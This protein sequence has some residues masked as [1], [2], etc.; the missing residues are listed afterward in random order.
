M[1]DAGCAVNELVADDYGFDVHV[2]LPE[3]YP[4]DAPKW[5]MSSQ[6]ALLQIKGGKSFDKGVRLTHAMWRFYL[7]SPTPTYLAVIPSSAAPW[8]ELVDRLAGALDVPAA[9]LPEGDDERASRLQP[10]PGTEMW[11]AQLF[12]ED[13]RLYAAADGRRARRDLLAWAGGSRGTGDVDVEFL[14]TLAELAFSR[15]GSYE[16]LAARVEEYV[17][18]PLPDYVEI[19]ESRGDEYAGYLDD[20]WLAERLSSDEFIAPG[21]GLSGEAMQLRAL[22]DDLGESVTISDLVLS[23]HREHLGTSDHLSDRGLDGVGEDE[24]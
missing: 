10:E 8:I 12:I 1:L 11:N 20:D 4:G 7:R 6:S 2:L 14:V 18:D 17:A 13:A 9:L 5:P 21:G 15:T 24:E 19:L 3:R 23:A 22:V 16:A